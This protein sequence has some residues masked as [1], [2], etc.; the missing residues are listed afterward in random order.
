LLIGAWIVALE[1]NATVGLVTAAAVLILGAPVA[2][3][4]LLLGARRAKTFSDVF[5][6]RL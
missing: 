4:Y 5:L 2:L 3:A 6:A 1:R